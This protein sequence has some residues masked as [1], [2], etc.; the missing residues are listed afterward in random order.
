MALPLEEPVKIS[1]LSLEQ[2]EYLHK[3]LQ[4]D[5]QGIQESMLV[6]QQAAG[7]FGN[8][9]KAVESLQEQ[10]EGACVRGG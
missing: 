5:L 1:S 10:K 6:L 4:T 3:T 9:G 7:E 8:A 2:L